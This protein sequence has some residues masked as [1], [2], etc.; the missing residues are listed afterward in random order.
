MFYY[1]MP[2]FFVDVSDM[3]MSGRTPRIMVS[4][5]GPIVNVIIGGIISILAFVLPPSDYTK[6]LFQAAYITYLIA[7]LNL[8]PLLELDGYYCLMDLLEMPQLRRKSFDFLKTQLVPKLRSGTRFNREEI[9]YSIYSVL[10]IVVTV[11][12][13]AFVLYIWENELSLMIH[14][15]FTGQD[16][17]VVILLGGLTVLAES[18]LLIGFGALFILYLYRVHDRMLKS[19]EQCDPKN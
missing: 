17:R 8:N 5:A 6:A 14:D 9:I 2:T 1:G 7:L 15:I 16:I 3:W 13:L 10:S 19:G 12:I 11:L 18:S 4:L